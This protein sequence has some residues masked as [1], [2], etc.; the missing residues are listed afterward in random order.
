MN[1]ILEMKFG[2]TLYG[3]TTPESDTDYK[4]IYLPKPKDIVLGK[5][6]K[7]I[8]IVRPKQEFERNKKDDVDIEILSLCRFLELLMDG[9]TMALDML[10][11]PEPVFFS[12]NTSDCTGREIWLMINGNKEKLLTKN[13]SAFVGYARQQASR[14]GIKGSRMDA[15]KRTKEYLDSCD[16]EGKKLEWY[17]AHLA[18]LVDSCNELLS[19]EKT[20]LVEIVML[21]GSKGQKDAPHLRVNG[22]AIPLHAT[23]KYAKEIV[24]KMLESYGQRANKAH[25]AG[26]IDWKA[27]H[28]AVRVNNEAKE[29]LETGNI[30]FPRPERELLLDIK[31]GKLPY[32]Q[33]AEMI[34]QGLADLYVAQE[35]S[36]LRETPDR[37]WAD[38]F[39][40][41][42][43]S[44][45]VKRSQQ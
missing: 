34:E 31:L 29:L 32:E 12:P 21:K 42:V 19:L 2:S 23:V 14:Y 22:R 10:F 28:H 43:Y 25:L 13:V 38:N 37:E 27:L 35:R 1:K 39:I 5:I 6:N 40:Y 44:E 17:G 30:T 15:L 4:A 3:T 9:Q 20:A 16:D 8:N 18:N 45:I 26:G 33:V 7:S 36:N 24:N 41:E 11:C